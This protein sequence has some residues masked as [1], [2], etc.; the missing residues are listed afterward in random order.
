M[1]KI[2]AIVLQNCILKKKPTEG[3]CTCMYQGIILNVLLGRGNYTAPWGIWGYVP[4]GNVF[5]LF[6][7]LFIYLGPLGLLLV[8]SEALEPFVA[9][10][11]LH[12]EIHL[13]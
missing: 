1:N 12:F 4:P 6:I 10:M 13:V 11:L 2:V 3:I 5:Y 8:A 7:Y 9:E